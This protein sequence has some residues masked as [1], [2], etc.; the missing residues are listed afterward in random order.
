MIADIQNDEK[1][2]E[3]VNELFIRG[4]KLTLV[5]E[6]FSCFYHAITFESTKHYAFLYYEKSK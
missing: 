6:N 5:S 2:Y 3:L 1:L 4:R